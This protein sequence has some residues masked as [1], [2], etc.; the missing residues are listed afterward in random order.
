MSFSR[1]KGEKKRKRGRGGAAERAKGRRA[2]GRKGFWSIGPG[3]P[4][5]AKSRQEPGVRRPMGQES[6]SRIMSNTMI[7]MTTDEYD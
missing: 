3:G 4:Q 5:R 7:V 2:G 6:R 1:S